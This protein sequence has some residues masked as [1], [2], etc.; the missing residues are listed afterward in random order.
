MTT[1]T[2]KDGRL[3]IEFAL[4]GHHVQLEAPLPTITTRPIEREATPS[5]IEAGRSLE[6][7]NATSK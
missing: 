2:I 3:R 5:P 4:G 6:D 1:I 7:A